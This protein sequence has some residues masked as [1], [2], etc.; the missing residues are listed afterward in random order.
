MD[1]VGDG[2]AGLDGRVWISYVG[3]LGFLKDGGMLWIF[4]SDCG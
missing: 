4:D 2:E 1:V 3:E